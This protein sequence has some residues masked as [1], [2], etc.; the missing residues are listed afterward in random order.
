MTSY[1]NNKT[2]NAD[3]L[4]SVTKMIADTIWWIQY[5]PSRK[6]LFGKVREEYWY[7]MLD[8]INPDKYT[9]EELLKKYAIIDNTVCKKPY[10][11]LKFSNGD[12]VEVNPS[13]GESIYHLYDHFVNQ[14]TRPI[15]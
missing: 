7:D 4:V 8:A 15:V 1:F 3:Q 13:D 10:I 6:T 11:I 5:Q 14:I 12:K 9:R 2:Y